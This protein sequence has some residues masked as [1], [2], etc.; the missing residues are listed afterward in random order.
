MN[1]SFQ[2]ADGVKK[3]IYIT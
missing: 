1:E 3:T 2:E